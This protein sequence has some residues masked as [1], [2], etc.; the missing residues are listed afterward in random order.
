MP[1][2]SRVGIGRVAGTVGVNR[3]KCLL[4]KAP[5]DD[6]RKLCQR[7]LQIDNRVEPGSEQVPLAAVTSL[8]WSHEESTPR[9]HGTTES[10]LATGSNLQENSSKAACFWQ[11]SILAGSR[12][13]RL[14]G[15]LLILH[16]GLLPNPWP[17]LSILRPQA[18]KQRRQRGS[19]TSIPPNVTPWT[20]AT[21]QGPGEL[22]AGRQ[23]VPNVWV[24]PC[25]SAL[26][27]DPAEIPQTCAGAPSSNAHGLNDQTPDGWLRGFSSLVN[28]RFWQLLRRQN[29]WR[30]RSCS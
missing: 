4:Q 3:P 12:F 30:V 29:R 6:I 24:P 25:A 21:R 15:V 17:V 2:I 1:A 7:M 5:V 20:S 9:A 26:I 23:R 8:P 28:L 19:R 11:I 16:S 14:I 27:F 18:S 13:S 22:Q 10:P